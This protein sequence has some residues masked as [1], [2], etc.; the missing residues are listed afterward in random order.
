MRR[1]HAAR[2]CSVSAGNTPNSP[3][4]LLHF[5]I[6]LKKGVLTFWLL[7]GKLLIGCKIVGIDSQDKRKILEHWGVNIAHLFLSDYLKL[8]DILNSISLSVKS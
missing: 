4:P 6:I 2:T 1:A 7:M 3:L 5:R 8:L